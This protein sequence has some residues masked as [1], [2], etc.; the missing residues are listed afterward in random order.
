MYRIE[1]HDDKDILVE[2]PS[3]DYA[4]TYAD[5]LKWHI[6]DRLELLKGQIFK[7]SGPNTIHQKISRNVTL[8][9]GN[10]LRKKKCE[11]FTAPFD[12]RLPLKNR[13]DD[14]EIT[15]VVQPDL[16]VICD[17][18][19]LDARGCIG[20]PDLVVEILSPGNSKVEVQSK[21]E[22][23]QEAGV[24]EY[25][26]ISPE[27]SNLIIY[28]LSNGKYIGSKPYAPGETITTSVLPGLE[29]SVEQIFET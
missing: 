7:M 4:Y 5:Y 2:E 29:I 15:T 9:I 19:K 25:W 20:A 26:I 13:K 23:Y 10:F 12:V 18:S 27:V 28:T 21:F 22:L 1:H 16:C 3:A 11:L 14:T 8:I 17:L 24:K 6:E